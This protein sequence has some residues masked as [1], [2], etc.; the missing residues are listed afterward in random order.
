MTPIWKTRLEQRME[1]LRTNPT[2]VSREANL[3]QTAVRDWL[4]RGRSASVDNLAEVA[5]VLE[6]TVGWLLG[7]DTLTPQ[8]QDAAISIPEYDVRVS[9]GGG[10]HIDTE[11]QKDTWPFSRS[12]IEG[13]LRLPVGKLVVLEAIGDSMFPT[14][15]SGDRI[16]V[17]M[18]DTRISQPGI[19]VLWDGD[20][21]VVKR[22]ELIPS[23]E[24]AKIRRI[25]DNPLHGDYEVM[26]EDTNIIGRVV[27]YARRM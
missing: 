26:A 17:N 18:A 13:E 3:G 11:T 25:S 1:D 16:L 20:G 14:I 4:K 27:W 24:P 5:R 21:T 23:T 9:A 2:E 12:Y 22:L 7:E 10:F 6:T 15:Q 8:T 19:F